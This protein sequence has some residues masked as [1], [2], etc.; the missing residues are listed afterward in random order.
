MSD[1][2]GFA[3]RSRQPLRAWVSGARATFAPVSFVPL[4]GPATLTVTHPPRDSEVEFT[5]APGGAPGG[6][7]ERVVRLP[8]RGAI[9]VLSRALRADDAH[10]SVGL[11]GGATVLALKLV[12]AGRIRVNESG[13]AWE[14]GPLTSDDT[15]AVRRLAT[16][17]AFDGVDSAEAETRIR[18]LLDAV[19]DSMTRTPVPSQP[20][21][22]P[23][24][25]APAEDD[26]ELPADVV[27]SLRIEAPAEQLADGLVTVVLQVHDRADSSH[28]ADAAALWESSGHGF[29]RRAR[30]T[31]S[32]ELRAAAAAWP[33]L[34]RLLREPVPDRIVLTGDEL[35]DLLEHG[36]A[37]LLAIGVDVFWP[38][39]L[40][41]ELEPRGEVEQVRG[42][43][44]LMTGLFG[45]D[46]MFAFD[47]RLALRN[48]A[49]RAGQQPADRRGDGHARRGHD[50]DHPAP[51][52]LGRDRP[53]AGSPG[54]QEGLDGLDRHLEAGRSG[55]R[56][57][58]CA[59]GGARRGRR[60]GPDPS[61]RLA[62]AGP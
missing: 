33:T 8:M 51:R 34:G 28:L 44:P 3:E 50:A 46:A 40:Q 22:R 54:A 31:A 5:G 17:R 36:V 2:T 43:S 60:G 39:G 6:P 49:G 23:L 62:A 61:R 24:R 10:P 20:V 56:T 7:R 16:A 11:L 21:R 19:A 18:G 26:A 1:L 4:Q 35:A 32:T 14:A 55:G 53:G 9:P 48:E 47:W 41:A 27:V 58:G 13:D 12:A 30:L 52:Q 15:D 42:D 45:P 57:P 59:D 25:V 38:R 29:S 37:A